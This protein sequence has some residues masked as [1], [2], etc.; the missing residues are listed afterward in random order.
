MYIH[1][2]SYIH[3]EREIKPYTD[4][5]IYRH[6]Y[7]YIRIYIHIYI[8][9]RMSTAVSLSL[10]SFKFHTLHPRGHTLSVI[11]HV[12]L[13]LSLYCRSPLEW[14]K[15]MEWLNGREAASG[16]RGLMSRK[17]ILSLTGPMCWFMINSCFVYMCLCL[18]MCACVVVLV[19]VCMQKGLMSKRRLFL[20]VCFFPHTHA[21]KKEKTQTRT[22]MSRRLILFPA[23]TGS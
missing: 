10:S 5:Y 6:I 4:V 15:E 7:V 9:A 13:S 2:Y 23:G 12:S 17:L 20:F 18:C 21:P 22:I 19:C 1:V 16:H 14:L 3:L 8:Y 11:L